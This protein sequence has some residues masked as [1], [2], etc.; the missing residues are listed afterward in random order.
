[1]TPEINP[2]SVFVIE[3]S[4]EYV[5]SEDSGIYDAKTV[6]DLTGIKLKHKVII[7]I[8]KINFFIFFHSFRKT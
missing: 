6:V 4:S 3:V 2:R 5:S 8:L 7:K 1:M